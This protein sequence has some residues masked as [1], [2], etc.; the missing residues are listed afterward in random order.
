MSSRHVRIGQL[1]IHG[2]AARHGPQVVS[3]AVEREV[4]RV[5]AGRGQPL[6]R[7]ASIARAVAAR[8]MT[9]EPRR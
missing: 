9:K 7:A 5:L 4:M 2:D 3:R 1:V 6:P 8:V